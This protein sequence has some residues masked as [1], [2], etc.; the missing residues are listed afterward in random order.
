LSDI[1]KYK[2]LLKMFKTTSIGVAMLLLSESEAS[3]IHHHRHPHN[4]AM[5]QEPDSDIAMTQ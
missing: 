3:H 4:N 1:F 2:Y 5:V